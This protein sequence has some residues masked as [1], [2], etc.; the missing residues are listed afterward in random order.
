MLFRSITDSYNVD[1]VAVDTSIEFSTSYGLVSNAVDETEDYGLITSKVTE[2]DSYGF[3]YPVITP[4][5][6]FSISG[7]AGERFKP[8]TV[9]GS[10]SITETGVKIE[11]NTDSYNIN[12]VLLGTS[13]E[14]YGTVNSSVDSSESYG[15]INSSI[16]QVEN[17]D[18]IFYPAG[19]TIYPYGTIQVSGTVGERFTPAKAVG[20]GS[21]SASGVAGEAITDFYG[22]DS[23]TVDTSIESAI[24]YGL[25]NASVDDSEDYGLITSGVDTS[26]SY[27]FIYPVITPFGLFNVSGSATQ[28][29]KPAFVASGSIVESGTKIEKN[30][31]SYNINSVLLGSAPENYGTVN[32]SVDASESYGLIT[33]NILDASED[34]HYIFYPAGST[35]YPYGTIQVSGNSFNELKIRF[36]QIGSGS[37]S[38]YGIKAEAITDS[39]NVDSVAIDTSIESAIN[40]G[41]INASVD[42][43]ENYGLIASSVD[44]S[45]SYGFIYPVITPFGIFSISGSATQRFKPAF[46]ASGSIVESGSKQERIGDVYGI[47][48]ILLGTSP[49]N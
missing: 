8:A 6:L 48:S 27:G 5:G 28:R 1:S 47:N 24:N 33:S 18:Y 16:D 13:P 38:A 20:S 12:S 44:T 19:S 15:L 40:Y 17:Y 34:Y 35:I 9:V 22:V 26:D 43:T 2:L 4:F 49:E 31:D 10:G 41:L 21:I 29:F 46:V 7:S 37:I 42:E 3:L 11:K 45:D 30:T 25:I 39:Y 36:I 23:I 14:N 32:T